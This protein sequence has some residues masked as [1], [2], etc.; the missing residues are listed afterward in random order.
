MSYMYRFLGY[1]RF[2]TAYLCEQ[3]YFLLTESDITVEIEC[4]G[5]FDR[6]P[7]DTRKARHGV[8]SWD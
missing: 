6:P 7:T 3:R 4:G 2:L 5:D 1:K 8:R